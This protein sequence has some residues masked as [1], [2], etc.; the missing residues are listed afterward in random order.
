M[1]GSESM[2]LIDYIKENYNGVV[3]QFAE[4]NGIKRQ[5]VS[6]CI[7]RGY[8]H[9]MVIDNKLMLVMAK[10]ELKSSIPTEY[11]K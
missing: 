9:V 6:A 4:A 10:K 8:Y 3:S 2:K 1:Q 7:D 5:Q 11:I